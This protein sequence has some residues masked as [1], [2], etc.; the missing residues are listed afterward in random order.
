MLT[1]AGAP[2]LIVAASFLLA[3]GLVMVFSAS[4]LRAELFF[5]NSTFFVLRQAGGL[6]IGVAVAAA[7]A[8]VPQVWLQRGAYP[9]WALA[10]AL[11]FASLTP[12]GL[13]VNGADR[14]VSFG[15]FAFQPLELAKLGLVLAL[16]QWLSTHRSR[17]RDARVSI[18]VPMLFTCIPAAALLAQPDFGGALLLVLFASVIIFAAGAR[19]DHLAVAVGISAPLVIGIALSAGYRVE[20]LRAFLNPFSEQFGAGFQLVQSLVAFGAGG[21]SGTGLGSGQQKLGYLPEAHTDFVLSVVGEEIGL[22]GVAAVLALFATLA[23][24][25]LGIASR[26]RSPFGAVLALGASLL[27]W[28]Q[29]LVNAGVALGVLPTTG[30]TLPLFSYGRT[31]LVVSLAAI[32]LVLNAAR[33]QRR[34]R[35]GWR[36]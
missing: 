1:R 29:G 28:L 32:G 26:A 23:L 9:A 6:L 7:I 2:Q 3:T 27:I 22:L 4:A 12:L 14:W 10:T 24:A 36:S 21:L 31:S 25:S 19:L 34:G 35:A 30:A 13:S 16:A 11:V 15:G 8:R 20:R 17:L 5:G 33:P 18:V